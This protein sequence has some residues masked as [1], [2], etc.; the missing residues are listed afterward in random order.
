MRAVRFSEY[1]VP[2]EVVQVVKLP[3]PEPG[4]G[5]VRIR[6]THRAVNLAQLPFAVCN[7]TALFLSMV[8]SVGKP[9]R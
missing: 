5:E 4:P 2:T 1:G 9:R 6:L 7:P 3:I 8:C